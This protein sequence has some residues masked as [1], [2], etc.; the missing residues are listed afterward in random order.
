MV[1]PIVDVV[2]QVAVVNRHF[3]VAV[4]QNAAEL[5]PSD[6]VIVPLAAVVVLLDNVLVSFAVV[7]VQVVA[8]VPVV[9]V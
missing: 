9:V 3:A 5:A 6:L 4:V 1:V 8:V 7:V 2:V